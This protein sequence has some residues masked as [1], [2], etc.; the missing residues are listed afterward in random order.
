MLCM[1][2]NK[3]EHLLPATYCQQHHWCIAGACPLLVFSPYFVPIL[4]PLLRNVASNPK[5]SFFNRALFSLATFWGEGGREGKRWQHCWQPCWLWKVLLATL[6][7]TESI[8][9]N[10][11]GNVGCCW[12]Y[13]WQ[14]WSIAG[15]LTVVTST[16]VE[17]NLL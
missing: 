8:A 12:Q 10:V 1:V 3:S 11:A 2:Q 17:V 4:C 7:A 13:C 5:C 15:D 14:A 9:G 16:V 6:L